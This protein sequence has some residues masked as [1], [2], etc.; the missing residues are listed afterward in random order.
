MKPKFEGTEFSLGD[1]TFVV[2]RHP[3]GDEPFE[4]GFTGQ[5]LMKDLRT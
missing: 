5:E 3:G 4:V 1:I 2:M